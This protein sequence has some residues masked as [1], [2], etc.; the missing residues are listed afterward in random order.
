MHA[1]ELRAVPLAALTFSTTPAQIERRAHFDKGELAEL[2][3]SIKIAGVLQPILARPRFKEDHGELNQWEVVAGERRVIAARKAGLEEI[4]A[5]V[6]EL[7]DGQVAELQLIENLQRAGL[8]ELAEAEGYEQ[9]LKHGHSVEEI[10]GKVGKS[11]AYVYARMKLLA[12]GP[13]AREAFY[14]GELSASTALLLARI[15]DAGAQRKACGEITHQRWGDGGPMSYREALRHIREDYMLDLKEAS[16]PTG[17]ADL[18]PAAGACGACPKRTG[19]QRELF[20][21]VKSGDV[22]TDAPCFKRKSDAWSARQLEK[23]RATGQE[24]ITGEKAKKIAPHGPDCGLNGDY[25][26]LDE[27]VYRDPK[28]RTVRQI[29]G[30][31]AQPALLQDVKT[32]ELVPIVK[33]A[34]VT[35]AL[36]KQGVRATREPSNP[37]Q[38]KRDKKA[39]AEKAFRAKLFELVRAKLPTRVD[40]QILRTIAVGYVGEIQ[41]EN[42]KRLCSIYGLEPI[43]KKYTQEYRPALEEWIAGMTKVEQLAEFLQLCYYASDLSVYTWGDGTPDRLLAAAKSLRIDVE[44]VRKEVTAA[45]KPKKPAKKK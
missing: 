29:I 32:G 27:R 11:K 5:T 14:R 26:K 43:K 16:F 1:S 18:V 6:R 42:L 13:A 9:L 2:A 10:A 39:K 22:C 25:L 44:K 21:D 19:N 30:K 37:E 17:D 20:Q 34:V 36:R 7:S 31:D 45:A 24:V 15:P 41:Q 40:V 35:E 23:A 4:P 12:L 38:S 33:E 8:H 28:Q 3:D